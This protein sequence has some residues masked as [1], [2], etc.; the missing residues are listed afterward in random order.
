LPP[1]LTQAEEDS[2]R[3]RTVVPFTPVVGTSFASVSTA[4]RPTPMAHGTTVTV[5]ATVW[6]WNTGMVVV[7]TSHHQGH[8]FSG[9]LLRG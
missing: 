1:G 4:P 7:W 8:K 5:T 6:A 2:V 9:P 3:Q